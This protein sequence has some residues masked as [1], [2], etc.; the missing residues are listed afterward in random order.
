MGELLSGLEELMGSGSADLT[1]PDHPLLILSGV[2]S[3]AR[4]ELH[5]E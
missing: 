4:K 2:S 5:T 1:V 3:P